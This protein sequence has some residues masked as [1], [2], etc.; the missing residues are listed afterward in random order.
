MVY[1]TEIGWRLESYVVSWDK[2]ESRKGGSLEVKQL[3]LQK[4]AVFPFITNALLSHLHIL[5]LQ[6]KPSTAA[7]LW[8]G[9]LPLQIFPCVL[10]FEPEVPIHDDNYQEKHSLSSPLARKCDRH[11]EKST[12]TWHGQWTWSSGKEFCIQHDRLMTWFPKNNNALYT[13][14]WTK[15][16]LLLVRTFIFLDTFL[17]QIFKRQEQNT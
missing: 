7:G 15:G 13:L 10:S 17:W 3:P 2:L 5:K 8:M 14:V 11:H 12:V 1:Q 4:K 6:E 16:K 9:L